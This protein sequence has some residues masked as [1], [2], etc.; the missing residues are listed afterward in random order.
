[1]NKICLSLLI[2]SFI[3]ATIGKIHLIVQLNLANQFIRHSHTHTRAI[4]NTQDLR[5][6]QSIILLTLLQLLHGLLINQI[7]LEMNQQLVLLSLIKQLNQI[8]QPHSKIKLQNYKLPLPRFSRI[9]YLLHRL[10]I[11]LQT[12]QQILLSQPKNQILI[13]TQQY[14]HYLDHLI[15]QIPLLITLHLHQ[16]LLIHQDQINASKPL[17]QLHKIIKRFVNGM[18]LLVKIKFVM[19][20]TTQ[21]LVMEINVQTRIQI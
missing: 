2:A 18:M 13:Q 20:R 12:Q 15:F 21:D 6:D 16:N 3:C 5:S 4:R 9:I 8:K 11:K 7:I 17:I 14:I 1:M 10:Q 19:L